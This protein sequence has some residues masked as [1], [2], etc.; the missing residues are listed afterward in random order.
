MIKAIVFDLDDTLYYEI[1]YVKS[2]FQAIADVFG[3]NNITL[4]LFTLFS[5][6]R[7]NVYQRY[8]FSKEE[9]NRCIE[10]YRSHKPNICLS[11]EIKGV[12]VTLKSKGYKLG[13]ITDGR[14]E[15]QWNKIYAL[16]LEKMV[17]KIIVTDELGGIEYRKP[18]PTA[19]NLMKDYLNL[20]YN[21][22]MYIGD[23][24]IK[25]FQAPQQ[26]GMKCYYFQNKNGLYY[27]ET[28][29]REFDDKSEDITE[30]LYQFI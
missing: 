19:F 23:N 12:L 18:N 20:E 2:G 5:Q 3:D 24:P 10:I 6:N 27:D 22:M 30:L 17:D 16:G 14:P 15:G 9:C 13:I 11:S 4:K 1:D 8:G 21:E 28:V 7:N 26:L 29:G 25:D